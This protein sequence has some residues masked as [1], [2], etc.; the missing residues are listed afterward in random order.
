MNYSFVDVSVVD[1][2]QRGGGG[3]SVVFVFFC[4]CGFRFFFQGFAIA[5]GVISLLLTRVS[6]IHPGFTLCPLASPSFLLYRG[7]WLRFERSFHTLD[8]DCGFQ[9][10]ACCTQFLSPAS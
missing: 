6:L 2:V 4:V 7:F 1:V 8:S 3:G 10:P 5:W 9:P